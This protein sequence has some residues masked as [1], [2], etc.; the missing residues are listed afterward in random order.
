MRLCPFTPEAWKKVEEHLGIS[1]PKPRPTSYR[2]GTLRRTPGRW[3]IRHAKDGGDDFAIVAEDVFDSHGKP[4]I[5]GE[6]FEAIRHA[7]EKSREEA[8]A[9]ARLSQAAPR[10][11]EALCD[12]VSDRDCLRQATVD[13][14]IRVIG[15]ATSRFDDVSCSQCGRS[16][17]PGDA[18][19]SHCSD[20]EKRTA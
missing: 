9:N 17:G 10:L 8:L 11:L 2:L 14:A 16:F 7:E 18:G 13:F 20:H 3:G 5:I 1:K 4:A 19:F 15:E 6:F 12:M